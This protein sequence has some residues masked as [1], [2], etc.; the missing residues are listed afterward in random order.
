MSVLVAALRQD[1]PDVRGRAPLWPGSCAVFLVVA[2]G[3]AVSIVSS[4]RSLGHDEAFSADVASLPLPDFID[5]ITQ[6]E[7]NGSLHSVLLKALGLQYQ[8]EFWLRFPSLVAVMA[9]ALLLYLLL[10][11][12]GA[13]WALLGEGLFLT[14]PAVEEAASTA[15]FYGLVLLFVTMLALLLE[16]TGLTSRLSALTFGLV[17]GVGLYTHFFVGLAALAA[18]LASVVVPALGTTARPR[19][20][21][22]VGPLALLASPIVIFILFGPTDSQLSWI[23]GLTATGVLDVGLDVVAVGGELRARQLRAALLLL[24]L[25]LASGFLLRR[26]DLRPSLVAPAFGLIVPAALAIAVSVSKPVL[27]GRYLWL[28][29][30]A[31]SVL[32]VLGMRAAPRRSAALAVLVPIL[33][34]VALGLPTGRAITVDYRLAAEQVGAM[35]RPGDAVIALSPFQTSVLDYYG[36]SDRSS[37]VAWAH[38]RRQDAETLFTT[39]TSFNQLEC[40]PVDLDQAPSIY[41]V[42]LVAP[43]QAEDIAR[44]SGRSLDPGSF[45]NGAPFARFDA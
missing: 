17:A 35:A 16:R 12:L 5:V 44:C 36:P 32:L 2:F 1:G 14:F 15:R 6:R 22:A 19:L 40:L 7:L 9:A 3:L 8:S 11:P 43:S 31:L 41:V 37:Q 39:T 21:W 30:P 29:L 4:R 20:L 33:V 10:R 23:P 26:R 45:A 28:V 38:L 13:G 34:A 25:L 18:L 27:V 42:G 24:A